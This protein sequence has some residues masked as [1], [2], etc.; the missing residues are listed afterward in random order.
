[1]HYRLPF[2]RRIDKDEEYD[3]R[4]FHGRG[5]KGSK[6]VNVDLVK[7][8]I[9]RKQLWDVRLPLP[10]TPTLLW[11]LIRENADIIFSEG[12]SSLINSSIAFVYSRLFKKKFI[13][14][15][16]GK[17]KNKKYKGIRKW[18]NKW[19]RYIEL[20]S[21]AIFTY[22]NQG[23][24]YFLSRGVDA[25]KIFVA[26]NVFDTHAKLIEI[27]NE[28]I[29]NYID[30]QF[31]N[32]A[33]IGTIQKTKKLD[34]LIETIVELNKRYH[35]QFRLH[36]IG[37]GEYL[38]ELKT[39]Y[40][41]LNSVV[42][43]GRINYGSSKILKNCDVMVLPGLGGLAICEGM[44]NRLAII[45][46]IAD[47]TEHDLVDEQNGFIIDNIDKNSLLNKLEVLYND[48]ELLNKMK[49]N[50]FKKITEQY[51]FE[52]YYSVFKQMINYLIG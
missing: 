3:F 8:D 9:P 40:S 33:F 52:N 1:M 7:V 23:K 51:S 14:W 21:D 41:I 49:Y 29:E 42:F 48:G 12:S 4:V 10:F 15:S 25:S 32:V 38:E 17:L 6:L 26:V 5:M 18:I 20:K 16:L 43:Y 47:G 24:Q 19:E 31:F 30:R 27:E 11:H 45:T 44:L 2:Y 50:S 35:E 28:Y 22:S 13:W 34:V 36:I 46:G 37:D 39:K